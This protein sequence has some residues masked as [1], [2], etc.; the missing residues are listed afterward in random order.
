M[1][2]GRNVFNITLVIPRYR[3]Q[4]KLIHENTLKI[5]VKSLENTL[6]KQN[7]RHRLTKWTNVESTWS[8][9]YKHKYHI[10]LKTV[11]EC[12]SWAETSL[13]P[14]FP[15]SNINPLNTEEKW[16]DYWCQPTLQISGESEPQLSWEASLTVLNCVTFPIP[17]P[18][19]YPNPL[20]PRLSPAPNLG[21]AKPK[22]R[23]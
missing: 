7:K 13:T 15:W 14:S 17:V 4:Q 20:Q 12:G 16:Q 11:A 10:G 18:I 8:I 3:R 21:L 23:S 22:I 5:L 19:P 6:L 9:S 2:L 1:Y